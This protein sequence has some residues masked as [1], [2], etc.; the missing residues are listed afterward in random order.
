MHTY[1]ATVKVRDPFGCTT[2]A[3]TRVV[4]QSSYHAN[5]LLVAQYGQGNVVIYPTQ[6]D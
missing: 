3:Q 2:M 6:C 1:Q 5:A 4:A